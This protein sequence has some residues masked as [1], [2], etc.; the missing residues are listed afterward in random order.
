TLPSCTLPLHAALPIY[1]ASLSPTHGE[2]VGRGDAGDRRAARHRH[3]GVVL[4]RAVDAVRRLGVGDHVIEL[5]RRLVVDGR[6]ALAA[7]QRSE[8][9]TSELQSRVDLV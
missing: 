3:G 8:E 7:I 6:P 5:G 1:I 9:H 2:A 4:L